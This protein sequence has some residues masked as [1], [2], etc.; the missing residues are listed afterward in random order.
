MPLWL[1]I[2][3]SLAATKSKTF[4]S[5]QEKLHHPQHHVRCQGAPAHVVTI[6]LIIFF[7]SCAGG[8]DEPYVASC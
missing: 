3:R 8:E 5:I 1:I 7:F 6:N 4:H 2:D